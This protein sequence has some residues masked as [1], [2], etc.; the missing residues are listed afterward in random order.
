MLVFLAADNG[1]STE[2]S[3]D[4]DDIWKPRMR[5]VMVKLTLVK[6]NMDSH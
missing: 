3:P 5:E 4:S 2:S 6:G 1:N